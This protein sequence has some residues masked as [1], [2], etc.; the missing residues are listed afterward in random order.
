SWEGSQ[1]HVRPTME[2]GRTRRSV[3][4]LTYATVMYLPST[5]LKMWN[6]APATSPFAVNFSGPPR[7]VAGS[8]VLAT[9]LRTEARVILLCPALHAFVIAFAYTCAAT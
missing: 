8:D 5:T 4:P 6:L 9:H 1:Q 2:M 7:I 3:S